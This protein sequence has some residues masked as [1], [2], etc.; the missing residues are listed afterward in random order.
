MMLHPIDR[1]TFTHNGRSFTAELHYDSDR[2][3][4]WEEEDNHGPVSDWE[5]RNKR[6]GEVIIAE[7]GSFKRFYDFAEACRIARKDGWDVQPYRTG[8]ARQIA[9]RAAL[10][11][12]ERMKAWCNNEWY[13]MGVI[14]REKG[15][16]RCCGESESLW[17]LESDC[18]NYIKQVVQEMAEELTAHLP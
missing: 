7:S 3:A 11:D 5:L 16:C 2:G 13:Y 4:P 18:G 10:A 12:M 15:A 17:G 8:T 9:A 1:F 14:V 6:P